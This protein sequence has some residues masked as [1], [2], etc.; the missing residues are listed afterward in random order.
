MAFQFET[1]SAIKKFIDRF[2][3]NGGYDP[4][5]LV[6]LIYGLVIVNGVSAAC[7]GEKLEF[8]MAILGKTF[9]FLVFDATDGRHDIWFVPDKMKATIE[10]CGADAFL[11]TDFL[12]RVRHCTDVRRTDFIPFERLDVPYFFKVEKL[13]DN[14]DSYLDA[15]Q[16]LS[17]AITASVCRA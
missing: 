13:L 5:K 8:R 6:E 7:E 3:D 12:F 1:G 10:D 17:T 14:L 2:S 11:V 15:V 9:P 16:T 4:D